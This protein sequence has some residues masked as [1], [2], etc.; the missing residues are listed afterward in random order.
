MLGYLL[1]VDCWEPGSP[2]TPLRTGSPSSKPSGPSRAWCRR[3]G[4]SQ[5]PAW[6]QGNSPDPRC[7]DC[8]SHRKCPPT[9]GRSWWRSWWCH[10]V[11]ESQRWPASWMSARAGRTDCDWW[12]QNICPSSGAETLLL[13]TQ[14]S[15]GLSGVGRVRGINIS[16]TYPDIAVPVSVDNNHFQHLQQTHYFTAAS[17]SPAV[18]VTF[19]VQ[20][21]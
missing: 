21:P 1:S 9:P 16:T 19:Q 13:R 4:H 2:R 20:A 12:C 5:H 6:S 15:A 18:H 11:T 14:T 8:L 7:P 3:S 17:V 10:R